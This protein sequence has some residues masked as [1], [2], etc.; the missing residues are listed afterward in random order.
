MLSEEFVLGD[1]A[2]EDVVGGKI[3]AIESKE[4]VTEPSVLCWNQRFEDWVEE[5]FAEVVNAVG[6]E[7]GDGEIVGAGDSLFFGE[8]SFLDAGEV[9]KSILVVGGEF[10]L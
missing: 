8:R 3:T 9:E 5:E 10:E 6:D 7:G 4:E 2:G 1:I